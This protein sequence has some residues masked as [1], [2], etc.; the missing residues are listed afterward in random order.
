M[1]RIARSA[2]R[3]LELDKLIEASPRDIQLLK[4]RAAEYCRLW[5]YEQAIADYSAFLK[6]QPDDSRVLHLR[7][8]AYE[9]I[10][11]AARAREDFQKAIHLDPQ[12]SGQYFQ[13]GV[14]LG[15]M[16][17]YRQSIDSLTEGLQLDPKN[18]NG[19]FNRGTSYFQVGDLESAIA[20]FSMVIQLSP[21]DEDAYYWRGISY[22]EAGRQSEAIAD[23]KQFL[24]IS[25]NPQARGEIEYRLSQWKEEKPKESSQV[26][27]SEARQKINQLEPVD[28][29]LDLYDLVSALGE[30]ALDSAWLASD[31][32]C[33]GEKSVE[34]YELADQEL[35]IDG[36][37]FLKIASRIR[38]TVK[39]DFQAFDSS[40]E[41]PW[42]F[43]RAWKGE[44][45]YV[46]TNDLKVKARLKSQFPTLEE[47]EDVPPPYVGLFIPI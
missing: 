18:L 5:N 27:A 23:Y 24:L 26:T 2:R 30:R 3:I 8:Q 9:Q 46:E 31:V 35:S 21:K 17:N 37:N 20:D 16:G 22:E 29:K 14:E 36:R 13:R 33:K 34:L 42:L 44:G 25:Q 10:G 38:Q 12:L 11:Q 45:F 19:Y 28:D 6:I 40:G 41:S 47:V 43:V 32:D 7:G 4:E 39:G 15:K 1:N